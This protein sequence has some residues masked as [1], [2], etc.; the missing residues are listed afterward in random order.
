MIVHLLET[1]NYLAIVDGSFFPECPEYISVY[2][3]FIC[4]KKVFS[5]R[6]FITI[7]STHLQFM[8]IVEV[9]RG[10]GI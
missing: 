8:H 2:W 6:D 3:K 9:C 7:V 1:N 5:S 4:N 10:L